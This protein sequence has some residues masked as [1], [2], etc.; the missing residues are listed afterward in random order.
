MKNGIEKFIKKI[1]DKRKLI[2]SHWKIH[3]KEEEEEDK[4]KIYENMSKP[5]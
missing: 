4:K 5:V 3:R 2:I 1:F